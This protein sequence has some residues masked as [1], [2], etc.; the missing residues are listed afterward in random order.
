[1][2]GVFCID[3]MGLLVVLS[4]ALVQISD[5]TPSADLLSIFL[6]PNLQF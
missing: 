5:K 3:E 1:M 6:K 4:L 2:N